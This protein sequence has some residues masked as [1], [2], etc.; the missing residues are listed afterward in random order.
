MIPV[1]ASMGAG[2]RLSPHSAVHPK[3]LASPGTQW[4][5]GNDALDVRAVPEWL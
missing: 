4:V 5:L 3:V 2:P 1:S